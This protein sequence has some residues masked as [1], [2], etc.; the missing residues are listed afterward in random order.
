[1]FRRELGLPPKTLARLVRFERAHRLT[2]RA[3]TEG[4]AAVA[5]DAGYYDQA[6]L[7]RDF[8]AFS[9]S[10]PTRAPASDAALTAAI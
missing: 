4:W 7:I 6:H 9:G 8:R 5:A 1:M 3:A 2:S 10:T